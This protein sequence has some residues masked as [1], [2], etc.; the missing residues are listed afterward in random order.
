MGKQ[1]SKADFKEYDRIANRIQYYI[2]TRTF[3]SY[4]SRRQCY[5]SILSD[6][7][8]FPDEAGRMA[9]GRGATRRRYLARPQLHPPDGVCSWGRQG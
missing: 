9:L 1:Q 5:D 4:Q 2:A 6:V 3:S 8:K 7:N